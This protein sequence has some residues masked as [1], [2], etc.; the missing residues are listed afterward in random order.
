MTKTKFIWLLVSM[1]F[2]LFLAGQYIRV[3]RL[4]DGVDRK[5]CVPLLNK[6]AP[7]AP[8]PTWEV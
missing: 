2:V 1:I 8:K 3:L 4:G 6:A 5:I 7:H